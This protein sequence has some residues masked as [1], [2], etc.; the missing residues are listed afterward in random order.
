MDMELKE[1][2]KFYA[3]LPEKNKIVRIERALICLIKAGDKQINLLKKYE[4]SSAAKEIG[5]AYL[6]KTTISTWENIKF[7]KYVGKGKYK[8]LNFFP[9]RL[10]CENVFRIEYYISQNVKGQNKICFWEGARI[11]K[12]FYDEFDGEEFSEYYQNMVRDFGDE[13][14]IY[15]KI[16]ENKAYKDP[17]PSIELLIKDSKLPSATGFY[18]HYRYLCESHHGKLLSL[19][20]TDDPTKA[21]R[22]NLFYIFIFA[23]WMLILVDKQYATKSVIGDSITRANSIIFSGKD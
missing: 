7:S 2:V 3:G 5:F 1:E 9:A 18:M 23:R 13:E 6:Y 21:Y 12:R 19:Y 22:Q 11:M 16:T 17:F 20:V 4:S 10:V 15:P 8:H 14:E